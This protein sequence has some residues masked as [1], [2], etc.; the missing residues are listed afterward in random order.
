MCCSVMQLAAL[1][2]NNVVYSRIREFVVLFHRTN[3]LSETVSYLCQIRYGVTFTT[4]LLQTT[5]NKVS[6]SFHLFTHSKKKRENCF[7]IF[8]VYKYFIFDETDNNARII[9]INRGINLKSYG[10]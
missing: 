7:D 6:A 9:Y 10:F 4:H 3:T 1:N 5:R 2:N 8:E